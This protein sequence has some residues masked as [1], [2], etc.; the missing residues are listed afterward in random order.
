MLVCAQQK[1]IEVLAAHLAVCLTC[2]AQFEQRHLP[3][4]QCGFSPAAHTTC[5]QSSA[6]HWAPATG[7]GSAPGL[8]CHHPPSNALSPFLCPHAQP[9][10]C[11]CQ[12]GTQGTASL[13]AHSQNR[14]CIHPD[15][16]ESF[17][18]QKRRFG[19]STETGCNSACPSPVSQSQSACAALIVEQRG[20][21]PAQRCRILRD[22][23]LLS[24][25]DEGLMH[26]STIKLHPEV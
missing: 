6:H 8:A 13:P 7:P 12:L 19:M 10:C 17:R 25:T 24:N 4:C 14:C 16:R 9:G 11:F 20:H 21:R 22:V 5:Q 18:L 1:L 23:T 2:K 15:C 26:D 3:V